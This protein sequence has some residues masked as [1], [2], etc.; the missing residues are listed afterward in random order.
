MV[1]KCLS[2]RE[3]IATYVQD[4]MS[5]AI[6]GFTAFICFAAGHEIIRQHRR[7][8][9]LIRMTPDLIYDQMIAAGVAS[10]LIFSYLGNPGVGALHC[11]RRAVETGRPVPL[12]LEEYSHYGMVG[13]YIAGAT[14][15]PFYPLHSY[16]GSEM[17]LVNDQIKFL[18]SP[19]GDEKVAAVPPLHPDIAILHAQR[20]DRQ[21]NTQ[22]WGLLGV[23]KEAAFAARKVIIV[24]EELVDE[25]IIRADPNRTLIPGLIVDAV[26]HLPYG[27]YPSYVQ[28]Y[29][30]RDNAFYLMWDKLSRDPQRVQDWLDEWVYSVEDHTEYLRKLGT[31]TLERIQP[32]SAPAASV[33]YGAYQ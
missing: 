3:A 21:G 11:V 29:Y 4:G 33:E 30:D 18:E 28:G 16:L 9:T 12:E 5:V 19:Y 13:R 20:A 22:L 7:D 23:Q 24:A 1:D 8:L 17:P 2:L 10:K 14:K 25:A 27:A 32:G 6:E 26:V 15:L 31:E